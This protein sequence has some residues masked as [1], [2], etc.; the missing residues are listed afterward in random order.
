MC[1]E[2]KSYYISSLSGQR[3]KK[4]YDIAPPRVKRYL[5]AEIEFL[6]EQ[7]SPAGWTL[8]LG[9]GYGRIIPD[10]LR[11]AEKVV[12]IDNS[13]PNL[14]FARQY[15]RGASRFH[16][17]AMDAARLGWADGVFSSVVCIQNGISAFQVDPKQLISEAVRVTKRNG[18]AL[19]STYADAFWEDRLEWFRLQARQGLVG[20]IDEEKTRRG[21]IVCRDGF[22]ATT[23][24]ADDFIDLTRGL[25]I[26]IDI[27][28]VD[29]SSLFCLIRPC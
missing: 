28:E 22:R 1:G 20:E 21:V 10:L 19:F 8:D 29:A 4:C 18:V 7:I 3:L 16:L 9:C 12:G 14:S 26:K 13:Q 27:A 17:L 24:S 25:D 23:F 11:K 2:K 6:L 5:R 15:L